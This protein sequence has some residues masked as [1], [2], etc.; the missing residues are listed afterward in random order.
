MSDTTRNP[1]PSG[2]G[3]SQSYGTFQ[4]QGRRVRLPVAKGRPELWV[5]LARPLPY[6]AEQV[7][8]VTLL[9]EGG[10][11]WLAVTAAVPVHQNNLDPSRVA[12]VDL[13]IIHPY[14]VVTGQAGL[15]VSG[16]ALRAESHL[17]LH[18]QQAR[19]ARVARRA[20]SLATA[21]RD[22][23]AVTGF[24]CGVRRPVIAVASARLSMRPPRRQSPLLSSIRSAPC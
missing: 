22:G 2:R 10:Q 15:L 11:L 8:A 14:A 16:R 13:G 4:I 6:S 21:G 1:R 19:Y 5:R 18:D 20:P 17:H 3:G 7:R 9:A 12:G 24:A 23:G